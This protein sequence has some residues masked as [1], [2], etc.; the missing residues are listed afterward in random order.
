[1]QMVGTFFFK[2][3]KLKF[4]Q[5]IISTNPADLAARQQLQQ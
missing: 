5:T 4:L 1:M 3:G 2:G